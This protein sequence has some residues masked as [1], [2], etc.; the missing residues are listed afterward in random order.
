M[1]HATA[2][3]AQTFNPVTGKSCVKRY[4]D[5]PFAHRQ[6]FHEGHCHFIHGHSWSFE[7]EFSADA[8]DHRGFVQDFGD[9]KWLGQLITENFD[10]ALVLQEDDPELAFLIQALR[11]KAEDPQHALAKLTVLPSSSSEGIADW[12]FQWVGPMVSDRSGGRVKLDRVT[13]FEDSRNS[14]TAWAPPE[15]TGL[16]AG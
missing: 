4:A 15:F 5:I 3:P 10:H 7:F 11:V 16:M 2:M 14:A 6:P 12:L 13:V 1:F 8:L 9:L